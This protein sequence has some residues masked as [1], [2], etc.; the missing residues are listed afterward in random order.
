MD[1]A[2]Q[3]NLYLAVSSALR[4]EEENQ[5]FVICPFLYSPVTVHELLENGRD[6]EPGSF[7]DRNELWES[8]LPEAIYRSYAVRCGAVE[9][10]GG[11]KKPD[12]IFANS[13][14]PIDDCK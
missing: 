6:F 13:F 7:S 14:P 4:G 2:L 12:Y 1:E 10:S 9:L 3:D 8:T 5:I 11:E